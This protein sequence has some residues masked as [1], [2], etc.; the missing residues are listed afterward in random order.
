MATVSRGNSDQIV[1]QIRTALEAYE[2]A[3]P[4]ARVDLYRQNTVSVRIRV[5]DPDFLGV[6]KPTRHANVWNHLQGLPEDVV[7]DI[8]MLLLLT[9]QEMKG[10]FSNLEFEDPVPS[11]L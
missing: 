11:I 6:D 7:G 4:N 8:S 10:S 9:P 5:V 3:H 2:G 1:E